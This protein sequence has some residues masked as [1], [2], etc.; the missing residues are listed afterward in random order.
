MIVTRSTGGS[1]VVTVRGQA[2]R[3]RRVCVIWLTTALV[4]GMS[5]FG[6]SRAA[7]RIL[8][9]LSVVITDLPNGI[10]ALVTVEGPDDYNEALTES[11]AVR[12]IPPGAY[13]IRAETVRVDG[14]AFVPVVKKQSVVIPQ[15]GNRTVHVR[16]FI[17]IPSGTVRVPAKSVE[18]LE[19]HPGR[20]STL[21]L[22]TIPHRVD[23]GD[24][25]V[26]AVGPATPHGLIGR[27]T[28]VRRDG[29]GAYVTVVPA[30]LRDAVPRG[31]LSMNTPLLAAATTRRRLN[32][33]LDRA[34]GASIVTQQ[35]RETVS[36]GGDSLT[37]SGE[38]SVSASAN[39][40]IEWG[41]FAEPI[42]SA[43]ATGTVSQSASLRASAKAGASCS[44][45]K[46]IGTPIRYAPIV[47]QVGP[48]PVVVVP[49]LRFLISAAGEVGIEVTTA[50]TENA[51]VTAGLMYADGGFSP[52]A[53]S[54]VDFGF[55]PPTAS[56]EGS[57][58]GTLTA[59]LLLSMYGVGGPTIEF[60]A[61]LRFAGSSTADPPWTLVGGFTADVNLSIPILGFKVEAIA[62]VLT[63]ERVLAQGSS[64][65][66]TGTPPPA[67]STPPPTTGPSPPP[68]PPSTTTP[69]SPTPSGT[70]VPID[71][72]AITSYDEMR[73]GAPYWG[74]F[75]NAWQ[76]FVAQSDTITY[77]GVTVGTQGFPSGEMVPATVRVRLCTDPQCSH[78]LA[79]V[80]PQIRNYGNTEVDIGDVAV[81]RGGTYYVRWDQPAPANGRTWDT[82]WWSHS[83]PEPRGRRPVSESDR[84]QMVV[85]GYNR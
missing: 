43:T 76:S 44:I 10:D 77:L 60:D 28:H 13:T 62:N 30:R 4:A 78:T 63:L 33:S 64:P 6:T 34:T 18:D 38:V 81:T 19:R 39:I 68:S 80:S 7:P 74:Y 1:T 42:A 17:I 11:T 25:L 29:R 20:S 85:K 50:I 16:Y 49:E 26:A 40:E 32:V 41:G 67:P 45:T 83:P 75:D 51:E 21:T 72:R 73:P 58:T 84:M 15:A 66:P 8:P 54:A 12:G 53:T 2:R 23:K 56:I 57:V 79:D 47:L 35:V 52:I 31:Y 5:V 59:Q 82:F 37:I 36:C 14:N 71:R 9:H 22:R 3:W 69:P 65:V 70:P 24:V 55:E 27:V 48:V 61:Y 46:P